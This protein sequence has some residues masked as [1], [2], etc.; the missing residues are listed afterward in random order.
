MYEERPRP[1]LFTPGYATFKSNAVVLIGIVIAVVGGLHDKDKVVLAIGIVI[2]TVGGLMDLFA[3]QGSN[4]LKHFIAAAIVI[5][6]L[7]QWQDPRLMAEWMSILAAKS[8][9]FIGGH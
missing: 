5:A 7:L 3:R 2:V 9:S 6:V 4:K 1:G 8:N